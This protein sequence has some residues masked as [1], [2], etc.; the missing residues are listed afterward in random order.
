V[1]VVLF[2]QVVRAAPVPHFRD[3]AA[4][5]L[6]KLLVLEEQ[7]LWLAMSPAARALLCD[8]LLA[9]VEAETEHGIRR[10]VSATIADLAIAII[11][12]RAPWPQ[13][14]VPYLYVV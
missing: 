1:D 10:A 5:V 13:L 8:Q 6:R 3:L 9:A 7:S 14:Y 4:V 2:V 11:E 12:P